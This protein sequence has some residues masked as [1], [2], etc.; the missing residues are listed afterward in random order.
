[1]VNENQFKELPFLTTMEKLSFLGF[2]AVAI[3]VKFVSAIPK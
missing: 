2:F 1:M 3:S